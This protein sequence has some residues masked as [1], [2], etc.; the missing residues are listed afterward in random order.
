VN[1]R[2]ISATVVDLAVRGHLTI[3]EV[4]EERALFGHRTDWKLTR[5]PRTGDELLPYERLLLDGLFEDGDVVELGDLKQK[6]AARYGTVRAA[7]Y[8]DALQRRWFPAHPDHIRTAGRVAGI[9]IAAAAVAGMIWC[10]LTNSWALL[11][12]PL[13]FG[14]VALA[15]LAGW[16]P[17]RGPVGRGVFQRAAGFRTFIERSEVHRADFAERR[18]LFSEYL[19][20]AVALGAVGLWSQR[21]AGLSA[22]QLGVANWWVGAGAFGAG[23]FDVDGFGSAVGEFSSTV[24]SSLPAT[25]GS[26]GGSGVG[27]GFSGGGGG[28][29][30]GGS[31]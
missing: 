5:T 4:R 19:P 23:G 2:D 21:F 10:L 3:E 24:S 17:R 27:G 6:F 28:G 13:A 9:L 16:L 11:L 8:D 14:G 7:I 26:S 29:G 31:W 15:V 20:Y 18:G 25:A 1:P 30:G 22:E 12:V